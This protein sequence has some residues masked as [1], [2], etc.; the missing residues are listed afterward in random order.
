[1]KQVKEIILSPWSLIILLALLEILVA[2]SAYSQ[3]TFDEA[4]WHY[5]G[6]NWFR[7]GMVPYSGGVDNKSPFIYMIYGVSDLLFGINYWFPRLLAIISQSVGLYFVYRITKHLSHNKAGILAIIFYGLSLTWKSTDANFVSQAQAYEVTFLIIAFYYY[8]TGTKNSHYVLAG[9][10]AGIA[11]AFK[12][13]AVLPSLIIFS[14]LFYRKMNQSAFAYGLGLIIS[15]CLTLGLFLLL[16]INLHDLF[17]YSL[18]D[19]FTTG[20]VTD[21]PFIWK[22]KQFINQFFYSEMILFYPFLIVWC[23]IKRKSNILLFWLVASFGSLCIIGMFARSHLK[24]LLPPLSIISAISF[25]FLIEKY[26]ISIRYA[27][28]ALVLIFFPRTINPFIEFKNILSN[29]YS[30]ITNTDE[31]QLKQQLGLWIKS[32]TKPSEKVYIAGYS[33]VVQI[34]SERLSPSVYFNATQT[35]LAKRQLFND[36]KTDKPDLIA[37]PVSKK[38]T[39]LIDTDIRSEVNNLVIKDYYEDTCLFK[40]RIYRRIGCGFTY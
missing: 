1:M 4:I 9:I 36:L 20:S 38:Y 17:V 32:N 40:Y 3:L 37:I 11:I 2:F 35:P 24:E 25:S 14:I 19:N 23:F 12:L 29:N 39:S 8:F 28:I 27:V 15:I 34:Y 7:Y 16:G 30:P 6:R 21:H 18:S 26:F 33:A 10:T 22:V 5:I 13:T 31:D